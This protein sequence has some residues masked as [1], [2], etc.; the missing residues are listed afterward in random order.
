MDLPPSRRKIDVDKNS[1]NQTEKL[2]GVVGGIVIV[3][4]LCCCWGT[5]KRHVDL[6]L[7]TYFANVNSCFLTGDKLLLRVRGAPLAL[8]HVS[9]DPLPHLR[10]IICAINGTLLLPMDRSFKTI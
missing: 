2:F 1:S 10:D 6:V 8:I 9:S 7:A 3:A 5:N 4:S